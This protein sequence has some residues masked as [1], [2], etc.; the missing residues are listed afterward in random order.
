MEAFDP[1][2]SQW[3]STS[4]TW[5]G[6]AVS[7]AA[8]SSNT[9]Q[10]AVQSA[11]HVAPSALAHSDTAPLT[12]TAWA[13]A[14][15]AADSRLSANATERLSRIIWVKLGMASPATMANTAKVTISSIKVKPRIRPIL[16][17]SLG[18]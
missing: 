13:R 16:H 3:R 15:F 14:Y 10:P 9:I 1:G 17:R 6:V 7:V 18:Y 5:G 4:E 2:A 8:P 12:V 11:P